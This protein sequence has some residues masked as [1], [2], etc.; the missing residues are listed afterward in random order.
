MK[1]KLFAAIVLSLGCAVILTGIASAGQRAKTRVT[2]HIDPDSGDRDSSSAPSAGRIARA[3]NVG[4]PAESGGG[5]L[6]EA[7]E[8]R[9]G[10]VGSAGSYRGEGTFTRPMIDR[11]LRFAPPRLCGRTFHLRDF[12]DGRHQAH[13]EPCWRRKTSRCVP[14]IVIPH[15]IIAS[16]LSDGDRGGVW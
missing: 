6:V 5:A 16:I 1:L 12:L 4:M 11:G 7:P 15:V 13:A 9:R 10:Q 8:A 2:F 14:T 3:P